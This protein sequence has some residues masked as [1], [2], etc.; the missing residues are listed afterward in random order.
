[1]YFSS[2]QL[3]LAVFTSQRHCSSPDFHL[4]GNW[5][6]RVSN[7]LAHLSMVTTFCLV[8][9]ASDHQAGWLYCLSEAVHRTACYI[10]LAVTSGQSNHK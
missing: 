2:R 8:G 1:M 7:V 5:S 3:C 9:D 10:H 4:S 6:L